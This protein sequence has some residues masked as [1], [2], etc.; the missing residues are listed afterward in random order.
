MRTPDW[1]RGRGAFSTLLQPFACIYAAAAGWDRTHTTPLR[2]PLPVIGI[3]NA[4]AGGAGKTPTTLALAPMLAALGYTPH[5]LTRGY[6]SRNPTPL[7]VTA[8]HDWQQVGDEA[9]LLARAAPTWV[10]RNR[11]LAARAAHAAGATLALADDALQHH[12]LARDLTLLVVD[13]SYGFGNGRLLPAGPLR[14]PVATALD[15]SDAVVLIGDNPHALHFDLP[16]FT[17]RITPVGNNEDLRDAR[18]LAFA[19]LARPE[20]FY[21]SLRALGAELVAT[22]DYPDHHPFTERELQTLCDMAAK[23]HAIPI[24]TAKDA[25]K[26]PAAFRDRIRT[27]DVALTFDDPVRVQNWLQSRLGAPI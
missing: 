17:A 14:E 6:G 7:H 24:A 5:I 21:A 16:T 3:G 11:L 1:W 27:L 15:R 23:Y 13:G 25:V 19:G 12:R 22:R 8:Q 18:L 26:F 2:A 10:C 20:K 4:V 9:L